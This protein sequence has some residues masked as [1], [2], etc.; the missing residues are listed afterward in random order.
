[1]IYVS[2]ARNGAAAGQPQL[3]RRLLGAG[4]PLPPDTLWIDMVEPTREEDRQVE[5]FLDISIPTREEML[6]IE[7]SE[8]LYTEN[9]ARYM[10]ARLLCKVNTAL[11]LGRDL[12][13]A[14]QQAHHRPL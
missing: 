8:L 12:H 11:P 2:S 4:E 5:R 7:P 10:T 3:E 6:D 9:G 13:P 1:M 14:G